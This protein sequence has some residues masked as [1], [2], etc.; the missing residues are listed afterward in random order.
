[1][2]EIQA[3]SQDFGSNI[4]PRTR[5]ALLCIN[6]E[7]LD[8]VFRKLGH[9]LLQKKMD[10]NMYQSALE[11]IRSSKAPAEAREKLKR[12]L[13]QGAFDPTFETVIDEDFERNMD[14]CLT[15]KINKAIRSGKI[16]PPSKGVRA[17]EF[18]HKMARRMKQ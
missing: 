14:D 11:V 16:P 9:G 5:H 15:A 2:K 4:D 18:A 17:D 7:C 13:R 10:D 1:M 8:A 12:L 6:Q 3:G